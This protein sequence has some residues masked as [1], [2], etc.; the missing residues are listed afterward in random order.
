MDDAQTLLSVSYIILLILEGHFWPPCPLPAKGKGSSCPSCPPGSGVPVDLLG[1]LSFAVV[2]IQVLS[3][4]SPLLNWE[5][6]FFDQEWM[7]PYASATCLA[8]HPARREPTITS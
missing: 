8:F 6:S 1:L 2:Q 5:Q 3:P 7:R 4:L